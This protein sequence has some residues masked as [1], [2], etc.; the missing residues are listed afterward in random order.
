[1]TQFLSALTRSLA[2]V[3]VAIVMGSGWIAAHAAD[4][5]PSGPFGKWEANELLDHPLAGRIWSREKASFIGLDELGAGLGKADYLLLGEVH[6][7]PDAHR[8]QAWGIVLYAAIKT[9]PKSKRAVVMEMLNDGQQEA[10]DKFYALPPGGSKSEVAAKFFALVDWKHSGWP[11]EKIYAPIVNA[12][13]NWGGRLYPGSATRKQVR[14]IGKFGFAKMSAARLKALHLET[15]M[16]PA[17]TAELTKELK[18]G[19][20]NM[21]PDSAIPNMIKVQRFRDAKM[22]DAMVKAGQGS[23]AILIA[24][25]GHVGKDRA[26]PTYLAKM[27]PG[28]AIVSLMA[29][30]V[31]KDATD[32]EDYIP[33]GPGGKAAADYIVLTPRQKRP[34]QCEELRK[35]FKKIKAQR[36]KAK[37]Q[38]Q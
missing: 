10:L 9:L 7:N 14:E 21:L 3:A 5:N 12:T 30:E 16:T 4:K 15:E 26:V 31:R 6:D 33:R 11:D 17:L 38:K 34:D 27:Q 28:K 37:K 24:G 32:I 36:D 13:A 1:M 18:D 2:A 8:I 20:C 22:A 19:H 35:M 23:G 25:N 29:L